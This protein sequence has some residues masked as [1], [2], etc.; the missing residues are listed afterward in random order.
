MSAMAQ[1]MTAFT[2]Y[3]TTLAFMVAAA[4]AMPDWRGYAAGI[5]A[6]CLAIGGTALILSRPRSGGE[7]GAGRDG[8]A[9]AS[10]E[11]S[12]RRH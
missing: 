2:A 4:V 6:A 1:C 11:D 10:P 8:T 9:H 7:R 3:A 5:L 12:P